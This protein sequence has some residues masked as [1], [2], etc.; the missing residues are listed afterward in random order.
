MVFVVSI[1]GAEVFVA[2]A[3]SVA[4]AVVVQEVVFDCAP[5]VAEGSGRSCRLRDD[6]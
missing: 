2:A 1:G 4:T 6:P 5:L 3:V